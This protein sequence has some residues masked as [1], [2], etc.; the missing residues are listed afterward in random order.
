[1]FPPIL[2]FLDYPVGLVLTLS[3]IGMDGLIYHGVFPH[4]LGLACNI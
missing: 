2:R 3:I 1:M 4:R